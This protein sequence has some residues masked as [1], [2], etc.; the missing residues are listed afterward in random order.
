[1]LIDLH[2]HTQPLSVV[3]LSDPE[4]LSSSERRL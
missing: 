2:T 3:I 1:M 4:S